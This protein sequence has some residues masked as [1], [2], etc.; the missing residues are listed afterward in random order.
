MKQRAI[1]PKRTMYYGAGAYLPTN[2]LEFAFLEA[3]VQ[4][5]RQGKDTA[6]KRGNIRG[7]R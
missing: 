2:V 6:G 5:W 7:I 1:I 3:M 4:D